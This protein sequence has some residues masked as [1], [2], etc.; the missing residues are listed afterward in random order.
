MVKTEVSIQAPYELVWKKKK[1]GF[2]FEF[3]L[4][5]DNFLLISN[6]YKMEHCRLQGEGYSEN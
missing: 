2:E 4:K 3:N 6:D 1:S 5:Q